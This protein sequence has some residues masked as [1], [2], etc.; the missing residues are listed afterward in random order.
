MSDTI[1]SIQLLE[2]F[3]S[4]VDD[5]MQK[6]FFQHPEVLAEFMQDHQ[7]L[8]TALKDED[9]VVDFLKAVDGGKG[10]V[11]GI[12]ATLR[13]DPKKRWSLAI[14]RF[15]DVLEERQKYRL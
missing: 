7:L 13:K 15:M 10:T 6:R 14:V 5:M 8:M 11:R 12:L 3:P 1:E 9:D 4:L 2:R